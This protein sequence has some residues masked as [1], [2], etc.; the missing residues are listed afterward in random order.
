MGRAMEI[1][2]GKVTNPS[3]TFTPWTMATG[4]SNAVRS[5]PFDAGAHLEDAWTQQASAGVLR[6]RSPRMHDNLQNIRL[7]ALA[8]TPQSL[9]PEMVNQRLYPQDQ[10]IIDQTGGA[11]E[12]DAGSLLITYNDL[13]GVNA[14]FFSWDQVQPLI[15]NIIS[16]ETQHTTGGTAGDYGGSQAI[17][18]FEDIFKANE[19]YAVLGY[20]MSAA[21]TSVGWKSPDYGNLRVGGPGTTQRM[22]TRDYFIDLD[23][24]MNGPCIPVWNAANKGS[25]FVDLL[26][27]ATGATVIVHTI[28]AELGTI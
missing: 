11:S 27:T 9:L 3:T 20:L 28:M 12:V 17:N 13:P 22:E 25:T 23:R 19:D 21:C 4:D 15:K 18:S 16:V 1:I 2:S 24:R 7:G 14:R 6:V 26:S 10:L 8:A 5:F